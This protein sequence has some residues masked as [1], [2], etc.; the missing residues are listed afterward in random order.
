[1]QKA[2]AKSPTCKA[3]VAP[4]GKQRSRHDDNRPYPGGPGPLPRQ[5]QCFASLG[6]DIDIQQ[7]SNNVAVHAAAPCV[8]TVV[9]AMVGRRPARCGPVA[10]VT[11][12]WLNQRASAVSSSTS[13]STAIKNAPAIGEPASGL[14]SCAARLSA[15]YVCHG[16][17]LPSHDA[18]A[19]GLC[20]SVAP[21]EGSTLTAMVLTG[22]PVGSSR[23]YTP[24]RVSGWPGLPAASSAMR[25]P[26][27]PT[28]SRAACA[29]PTTGCSPTMIFCE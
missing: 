11:H 16:P 18:P 10:S 23:L 9:S 24:E 12:A 25:W 17:E 2:P 6:D 13:A 15:S 22:W 3:A 7:P 21:A 28:M 27:G 29:T 5:A 19:A 4:D 26:C 8:G 20:A 1:R 14:P